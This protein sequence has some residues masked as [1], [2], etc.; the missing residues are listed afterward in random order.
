[1]PITRARAALT[2]LGLPYAQDAAVTR[3][4]AAFLTRQLGATADLE[5]FAAQPEDASSCTPP[6]CCSTAAC[7]SPG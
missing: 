4:L 7:S 1:M 6:R 2:Q 5:G 3:H